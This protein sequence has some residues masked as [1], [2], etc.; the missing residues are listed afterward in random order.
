MHEI[1]YIDAYAPSIPTVERVDDDEE[2]A[3]EGRNPYE[4]VNVQ[5][6]VESEL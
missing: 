2:E 4:E 5:P 6:L 3:G 1:N